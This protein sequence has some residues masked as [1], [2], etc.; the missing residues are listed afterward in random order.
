MK[1]TCEKFSILLFALA[2]AGATA[3]VN[4]ADWS[5][6]M[7]G[8]AF[9]TTRT[10]DGSGLARD[11]FQRDGT[12]AWKD[13]DHI[14]T[15]HFHIDRPAILELAIRA[16]A[17]AGSVDLI[18]R[19]EGETFRTLIDGKVM[20]EHKVG[21]ID[22]PNSGYVR[23]DFQ[24]ESQTGS[25]HA[26]IRDLLVSSDTEGLIVD[27]VASNEGNMFY[28]GRR[29]P[30]VHLRYEVPSE[31]PLQY[32]YSEI[33]VPPGM[34]P[35]GSF[36]MANGFG[37]GYF[38]IQVNGPEE[39][40][41]LFSVWSPFR[42]DDPRD[43]PVDQRIV[44]LGKGTD[45]HTG[46]FGNEGSGGQSFLV[47]PWKSGITY[48]F[49]TEVKPDGQGS[50]IYTSWFSEKTNMPWRLI[51][52]FRRPKTDT[53]LRGFHSFLES[54]APSS[55]YI[56]RRALYGNVWV[57]DTQGQWHECTRA[58]FSV[59]AT[60]SGRHRLDFAGGGLGQHFYLRN[61]GFFDQTGHPGET[62]T[63]E[64]TATDQPNIQFDELPRG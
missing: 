14:F 41:V 46:E 57:S 15:V 28:W 47:Y 43:I 8:N 59:D 53:S 35:I 61:C 4:A 32:A 63:R 11:G 45:V 60:G 24:A 62:F 34:D 19:V 5:V 38:G 22:I 16:R 10:S 54:F 20:T 48:H 9:L 7:A 29:G 56:E 25:F 37:E 64:S 42:T 51:A 6:P 2:I 27:Y 50:T 21:R 40:R 30:S 58:R 23:V 13:P 18:T 55:G 3:K 31:Q 52:S 26:E 17:P 36:F 12:V 49:L 44:T 33:T 39:R 1:N